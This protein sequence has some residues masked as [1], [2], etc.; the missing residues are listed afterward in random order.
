[1]VRKRFSTRP[2]PAPGTDSCS[3]G[4]SLWRSV[5]PTEVPAPAQVGQRWVWL[6]VR[7]RHLPATPSVTLRMT[8]DR[9]DSGDSEPRIGLLGAVADLSVVDRTV[10]TFLD[11]DRRSDRRLDERVRHRPGQSVDGLPARAM[12]RHDDTDVHLGEL[13]DGLADDWL[14]QTSG[15]SVR[16]WP[17]APLTWRSTRPGSARSAIARIVTARRGRGGQR[18]A[19]RGFSRSSWTRFPWSRPVGRVSR[20]RSEAGTATPRSPTSRRHIGGLDKARRGPC[21]S[22]SRNGDFGPGGGLLP[23]ER[24]L[25]RT[26]RYRASRT[27]RTAATNR[28]GWMPISGDE[29]KGSSRSGRFD[30]GE[31]QHRGRDCDPLAGLSAS[32]VSSMACHTE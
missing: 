19:R 28:S 3:T 31:R 5:T 16:S 27:C 17:V 20:P 23:I 15:S 9:A 11:S 32:R 18:W 12:R 29:S 13:R 8:L 4:D 1:V 2:A 10:Q 24:R 26:S 14:E 30:P 6:L 7:H 25:R 22:R 21:T